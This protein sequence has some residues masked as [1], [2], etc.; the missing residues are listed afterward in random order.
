M[1]HN[2]N[3]CANCGADQRP[4]S[5]L[6]EDCIIAFGGQK[7]DDYVKGKCLMEMFQ[8]GR[9]I[10]EIDMTGWTLRHIERVIDIERLLLDR[11]IKINRV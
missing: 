8:E 11:T 1:K 5:T 10:A 2:P 4:G 9:K 3:E 6:C 7:R